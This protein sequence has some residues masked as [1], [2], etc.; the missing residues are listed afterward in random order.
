M[1]DAAGKPLAA[2]PDVDAVALRQVE[3]AIGDVLGHHAHI[4]LRAVA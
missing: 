2:L 1:V 3:R 4:Q